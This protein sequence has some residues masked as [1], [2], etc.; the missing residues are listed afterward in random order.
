[1]KFILQE[2]LFP[3]IELLERLSFLAAWEDSFKST[4]FLMSI[5]YAV[6]RYT[7]FFSRVKEVLI[8]LKSKHYLSNLQ[9]LDKVLLTLYF[10]L[11][12]NGNALEQIS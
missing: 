3:V 4:S 12:C 1:M 7:I 9:G 5:L 8:K 6:H 2:L 10:S 11:H